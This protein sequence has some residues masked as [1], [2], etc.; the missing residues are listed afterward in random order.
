LDCIWVTKR[1]VELKG[2]ATV[3]GVSAE[4]SV[5]QCFARSCANRS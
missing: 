3:W 1:S 4:C 2:N 5:S